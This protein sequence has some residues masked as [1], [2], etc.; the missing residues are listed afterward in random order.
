MEGV[1]GNLDKGLL[2]SLLRRHAGGVVVV[3]AATDRPAGFTATSFTS[4]SFDPPLVSFCIDAGSS[5]WPVIAG[6]EHVGVHVLSDRQEALARCFARSGADRFAAPTRWVAG[7]GGV[8][9]LEGVAAMLICR[10]VRRLP[11]G[12]HFLVVA[13]P[14]HGSPG[15]AAQSSLVYHMGRYVRVSGAA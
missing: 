8:P 1:T 12:D 13:E 14:V 11:L 3:T 2:R 7:P 9:V 5:A 6:A 15:A 4:V 10:V